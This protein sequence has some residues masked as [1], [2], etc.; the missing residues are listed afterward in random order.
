MD[1]PYLTHRDDSGYGLTG[2]GGYGSVTGYTILTVNYCNRSNL[3]F[4]NVRYANQLQNL[5]RLP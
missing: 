5:N 4:F 3:A 2:Y 1:A